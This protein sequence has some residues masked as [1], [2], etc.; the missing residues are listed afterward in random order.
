M[1]KRF[2]PPV[3][4]FNSSSEAGCKDQSTPELLLIAVARPI[5]G[6]STRPVADQDYDL[7]IR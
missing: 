7:P 4:Q 2:S 1:R 5:L 3:G 6:P